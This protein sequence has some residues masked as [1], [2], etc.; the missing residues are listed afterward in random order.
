VEAGEL[1]A[2]EGRRQVREIA[3]ECR[4]AACRIL[5]P[6]QRDKVPFCRGPED[7]G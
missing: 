3:H 7:A 4:R 2:R 6:E 1:T 5:E